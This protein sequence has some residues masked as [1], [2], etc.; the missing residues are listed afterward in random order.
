MAERPAEMF[1]PAG[2]YRIPIKMT[3]TNLLFQR[4]HAI[5]AESMHSGGGNRKRSLRDTRRTP[6][7]NEPFYGMQE[8]VLDDHLF[9]SYSWDL[10][11]RKYR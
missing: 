11:G 9:P 8:S 5:R 3:L 7:S 2:Y 6:G 10:Y 4:C 1:Y